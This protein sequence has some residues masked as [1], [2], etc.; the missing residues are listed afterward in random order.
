MAVDECGG[1]AGAAAY[2]L[3]ATAVDS[4]AGDTAML[5]AGG[6]AVASAAGDGDE[7]VAEEGPAWMHLEGQEF[8]DSLLGPEGGASG[9]AVV[10][11]DLGG[12]AAN[13]VVCVGR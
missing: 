3:A 13:D 2:S 9:V 5:A 10:D 6:V 7:A 11:G 12:A 4:H 1:G 8:F